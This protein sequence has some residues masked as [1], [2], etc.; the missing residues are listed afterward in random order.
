MTILGWR[1]TNFQDYRRIW[2][3]F[4]LSVRAVGMNRKMILNEENFKEE[5]TTHHE[6]LE[7]S[8]V[9]I[10]FPSRHDI[11]ESLDFAALDKN[12]AK[13]F[14]F[15]VCLSRKYPCA[16]ILLGGF[17]I[18]PYEPQNNTAVTFQAEFLS[19]FGCA[20]RHETKGHIFFVDLV[21]DM[22]DSSANVV[23]GSITRCWE[24]CV[25]F[26]VGMFSR[27]LANNR[28]L[29]SRIGT[30]SRAFLPCLLKNKGEYY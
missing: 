2:D 23:D 26:G 18:S 9:M 22:V 6:Q 28:F 30:S 16:R 25:L 14:T 20:L 19:R 10:V 27:H 4:G 7:S 15:L 3:Q 24:A 5:L 29:F 11:C 12:C 1:A 13:L 17:C 8:E 21:S